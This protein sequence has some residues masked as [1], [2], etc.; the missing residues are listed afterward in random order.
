MSF[1]TYNPKI[2]DQTYRNDL[3]RGGV[4]GILD[5]G[6]QTFCLF[7]AIRYFHAE[8]GI[9]SIIA[10]SPWTGM[11]ASLILVYYASKTGASKSLCGTI[12]AVF[13]GLCLLMSAWMNSLYTFTGLVFLAYMSESALFPFLTSIYNDNYPAD[14]RGQL[15]ANS[16]RLTV[17]SAIL[18]SLI[19]SRI[20]DFDLD[21]W[22]LVFTILG[23]TTFIKAYAIFSM[24]STPIEF[25]YPNPF[26]S[27]RYLVEDRSF[28]YILLTWFIM[29]FANLWI[30]P[31]RVDYLVSTKWG[32]NASATTVA[33]IISIIPSMMRLFFTPF[34]G[35]LFDRVNFV[36]LRMILNGIFACGIGLFF[37]TKNLLIIGIGTALIGFAF[38]GGSIAWNLWVTKYAPPGK[39]TV[40]MSLH[41]FLTGFRGTIGPIIGFWT[42]EYVGPLNMSLI[43]AGMILL[44]TIM[45]IPEIHK[46]RRMTF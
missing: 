41:V 28:G 3:L 30:Q 39:A 21:L 22:P 31:L 23:L 33:F 1:K 13:A 12:P 10:A 7:V 44:A 24:P 46:G 35:R 16:I 14:K 38:A 42:I 15:L 5:T 43:S 32:I 29:G 36:I 45:L 34:W 17:L 9:K 2:V 18:F 26:A 20:L 4:D 11:L 40:Y 8:F 19:G 37:I 25:G 6:I 27:F